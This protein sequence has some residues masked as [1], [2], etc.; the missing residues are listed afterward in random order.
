[1]DPQPSRR[2]HFPKDRRFLG[3]KPAGAK[4]VSGDES[5]QE[6]LREGVAKD[7]FSVRSLVADHTLTA[8][9]TVMLS[10]IN[11]SPSVKIPLV[12][13]GEMRGRGCPRA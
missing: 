5:K 7:T 3:V 1:M 8:L 11:N 13:N 9:D 2:A 12:C 6:S 4:H 10:A